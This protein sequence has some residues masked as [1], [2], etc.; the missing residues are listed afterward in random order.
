MT[1]AETWAELLR[2][3]AWW[4]TQATQDDLAHKRVLHDATLA[5]AERRADA[6]LRA[7]APDMLEALHQ[8]EA[9]LQSL[10]TPSVADG[11]D[12]TL[13]TVRAAIAKA[14]GK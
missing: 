11:I 10:R 6:R 12:H 7:A 4:H 8:A 3:V 5:Y 14:I 2:V 13:R 1:K 9:E